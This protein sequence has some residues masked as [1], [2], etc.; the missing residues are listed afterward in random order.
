MFFT[1]PARHWISKPTGR[2]VLLLHSTTFSDQP[3]VQF[4]FWVR[5]YRVDIQWPDFGQIQ[6]YFSKR[7]LVYCFH[8][9]NLLLLWKNLKTNDKVL[10]G[11]RNEVRGCGGALC[12]STS[13][14]RPPVPLPWQNAIASSAL[15]RE[16]W[17]HGQHI[18]ASYVREILKDIEV[19][20]AKARCTC[21]NYRRQ[22]IAWTKLLTENTFLYIKFF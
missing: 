11:Q 9:Y 18:L 16:H 21:I 15:K 4:L 12:L 6:C 2:L 7:H 20:A 22:G 3:E 13:T 14:R 10:E 8:Q 5:E 19:Q 1:I 17:N